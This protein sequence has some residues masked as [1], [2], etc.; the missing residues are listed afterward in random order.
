MLA[1]LTPIAGPLA[2]LA[3]IGQS[4][5]TTDTVRVDV[6]NILRAWRGDT[7]LPRMI[8][9]RA[10][11]EA[12]GWSELRFWSSATAAMSP[13]LQITYVPPVYRASP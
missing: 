7:T 8:V 13:R 2:S 3:T 6:T 11:P 10:A 1:A 5:G 12:G 4:A 9:L